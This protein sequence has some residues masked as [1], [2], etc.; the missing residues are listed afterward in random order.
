MFFFLV[1]SATNPTNPNPF[2]LRALEAA[3]S[4]DLMLCV[5][6]TLSVYPVGPVGKKPG[7]GP[8]Q[9]WDR[10][11]PG[12]GTE[13]STLH[14]GSNRGYYSGSRDGSLIRLSP[15]FYGDSSRLYAGYMLHRGLKFLCSGGVHCTRSQRMWCKTCVWGPK[16][17]A[18]LGPRSRL[19]ESCWVWLG[20]ALLDDRKTKD[21]E[22]RPHGLRWI[23]RSAIGRQTEVQNRRRDQG[24]LEQLLS[25][26]QTS[27]VQTQEGAVWNRTSPTSCWNAGRLCKQ[28][29]PTDVDNL[30][31]S[32]DIHV[33]LLVEEVPNNHLGCIKPS[34]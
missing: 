9:E 7:N 4:C 29:V 31:G 6:S 5:G 2:V 27:L 11:V 30:N 20:L 25:F 19:D 10:G 14:I 16:G 26:R 13:V 24:D 28:V 1:Q 22:Q 34:K 21:P 15:Q 18:V 23:G 33:I 12:K 17:A 8:G 3:R 32:C